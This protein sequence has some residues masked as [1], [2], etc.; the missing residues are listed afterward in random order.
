MALPGLD[1]ALHT[2]AV[3]VFG[4]DHQG[5]P[6]WPYGV[7]DPD[8]SNYRNDPDSARYDEA[9]KRARSA[10]LLVTE[11]AED[12][13][14]K[15][16]ETGCCPHWLTRKVSRRCS[17]Q[18]V[19]CTH[20]ESPGPDRGWLD[21]LTAWTKNGKPAILTSAPYDISEED[22]Q[23][24][25]WWRQH[26]SRLTVARGG[27]GWYGYGTT[28]IIMWRSDLLEASLTGRYP[29]HL[30]TWLTALVSIRRGLTQPIFRL[31]ALHIPLPA[32]LRSSSLAEHT[33]PSKLA[34]TTQGANAME[35]V[36]REHRSR[37][38]ERRRTYASA[39][40][41]ARR[42]ARS[43]RC[44]RARLAAHLRRGEGRRAQAGA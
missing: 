43:P 28:Q 13:G 38:R 23:R 20:Y 1:P 22:E 39:G 2:R 30:R 44:P 32:G 25:A 14:L 35:G 21:H 27:E 29:G 31:G 15:T 41:Y 36:A 37:I 10:Q 12:H 8:K 9:L 16:S 11:W 6:F 26:D 24:L 42:A 5:R 33:A 4:T 17:S 7:A 18:S 34:H 19:P 40:E 3:R